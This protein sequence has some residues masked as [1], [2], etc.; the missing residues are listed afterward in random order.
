[1][2]KYLCFFITT[3]FLLT[4][5]S[6]DEYQYPPVKLA[7]LTG[8]SDR[9]GAL[10]YVQTDEGDMLPIV[11]D[12]SGLSIK[13]DSLVRMV[14]NYE[15]TDDGVILYAALTAI[16]PVPQPAEAFTD[17]IQTDAADVLAI[18]MG[19]DYLNITLNVKAQNQSHVLHFIEEK[20]EE[21][22]ESTELYIRLYHDDGNNIPAYTKR[23]YLS[24]PLKQYARTDGGNTIIHFS[25]TTYDGTVK[26]Y[27]FSYTPH[28]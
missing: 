7:Y 16:A 11:Q 17:G 9:N 14:T 3:L 5:C 21:T 15:A 6:E 20:V 13:P 28:L 8:Y 4:A 22:D 19:W 26:T 25:L 24:I 12:G 18:W 23:A 1:M 27:D 10:Q 2:K